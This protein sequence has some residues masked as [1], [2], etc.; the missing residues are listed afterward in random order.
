MRGRYAY[1]YEANRHSICNVEI[2]S[3]CN[4]AEAVQILAQHKL[5]SA[6]VINAAAPKNASWIDK[7]IG[8]VEFAGIVVWLLQQSEA[9]ESH[10]ATTRTTTDGA[11]KVNGGPAVTAACGMTQVGRLGHLS[12]RSAAATSGNYFDT[13]TSS[14]LYKATK[15]R[16]IAGSFRWAPFLALQ[17]SNSMLT[18]LLL[19]SNYK[20]KSVPVVDPGEAKI[21]NIITQSAVIHMLAECA[22]L[23][24]FGNWGNK[25]LSDLGLPLM[26]PKHLIEGNLRCWNCQYVTNAC[27]DWLSRTF[28]G[29]SSRFSEGDYHG[30]YGEDTYWDYGQPIFVDL[31]SGDNNE[32]VD[33]AIALSLQKK[34]RKGKRMPS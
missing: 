18:V 22:G 33:R 25:K 15:V 14:E 5:L 28:G 29:S 16:D 27:V 24:W 23:H 30:A 26:S 17:K 12:P 21:N 6:P 7:Y 2:N 19:L 3:D 13:L 10:D 8:I 31:W 32:Y 34:S 11:K 9:E 20:M 1:I 4:L